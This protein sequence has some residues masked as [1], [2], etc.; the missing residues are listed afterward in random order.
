MN[1]RLPSAMPIIKNH[2]M[3]T[4]KI[5]WNQILDD[6]RRKSKWNFGYLMQI[7]FYGLLSGCEN[8]RAV[9]TFS[10]MY[11]ERIPDTTLHDAIIQIN[12]EPLRKLLSKQVKE[13]L[14]DH[15]L[16]SDFPVRITA[17]DGKSASISRIDAGKFSQRIEAEG[18]IYYNNR[19]LRAMHVSS[20]TKLFLAQ[21]EIKGKSSETTE[22]KPFLDELYENYGNTKLLEVISVDAGMTS[23]ENAEK[24]KEKNLDYI[25]ALKG[26]QQALLSN[27]EYLMGL[28]PKPNKITEENTNGK[29]IIRTFFRCVVPPQYKNGWDHIKE[30]WKI[31]QSTV[32]IQSGK[33]ET[34]TRYFLSSIPYSKLNDSQAMQAIRMHWGIENN[35][36]WLLDTAWKEDD[37]PYA[38]KAL[39]LVTL[40]RLIGYNIIARLIYRRLR[41]AKA[42]QM[43]WIT[44]MSLITSALNYLQNTEIFQKYIYRPFEF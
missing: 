31:D 9:E 8:L 1:K 42:R 14:R 40:M 7:L 33:I 22:F 35:G 21:R 29:K 43:S 24:V 17:I 20:P 28:I 30:F 41:K 25:M 39:I 4:L 10:E 18:N 27:A 38:N 44:L 37:S 36:Y 12:P 15:E 6:P 5:K 2:L 13:A 16:N 26:T 23:K 34:E 3:R 11:N 19:V 32:E